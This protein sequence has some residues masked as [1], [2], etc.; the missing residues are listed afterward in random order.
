MV[1]APPHD[2][3]VS[4]RVGAG[5]RRVNRAARPRGPGDRS[6]ASLGPRAISPRDCR[7]CPS[8]THPA[9]RL[10]EPPPRAPI[11]SSLRRGPQMGASTI[12]CIPLFPQ[13][14]VAPP[15]EDVFPAGAVRARARRRHEPS[16][17]EIY[18]SVPL[19]VVPR[20]LE[21]AIA[22]RARTRPARPS[23]APRPTA[24]TRA[25]RTSA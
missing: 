17:A 13:P 2:V 3:V 16:P 6:T 14:S 19:A 25:R 18:G 9:P 24:P 21:A 1:R 4:G 15:P 10:Y 20:L 22:S 23:H 7:S 5:A 8:R 11:R 12:R